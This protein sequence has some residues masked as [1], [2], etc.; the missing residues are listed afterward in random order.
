MGEKNSQLSDSSLHQKI[1]M[2]QSHPDKNHPQ[3]SEAVF[4]PEFI[5][6]DGSG[7]GGIDYPV[8]FH[9]PGGHRC[10][11]ETTQNAV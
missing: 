11:H 10:C 3:S 5:C 2:F 8:P 1:L 6:G 7:G 4:S 9:L